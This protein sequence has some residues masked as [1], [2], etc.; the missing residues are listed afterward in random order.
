MIDAVH[1]VC[2]DTEVLARVVIV[3]FMGKNSY[4][5]DLYDED[6]LRTRYAGWYATLWYASIL[7]LLLGL[8]Q[9]TMVSAI[10]RKRGILHH[11]Y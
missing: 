11:Y 6:A 3:G 5:D 2:S 8:L 9:H 1:R 7:L 10:L 4:D